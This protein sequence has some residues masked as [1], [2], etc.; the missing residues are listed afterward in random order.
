MVTRAPLL[1]PTPVHWA[2]VG[3]GPRQRLHSVRGDSKLLG[4]DLLGEGGGAAAGVEGRELHDDAAVLVD[5]GGGQCG[6]A[7]LAVVPDGN[8]PSDVGGLRLAPACGLCGLSE[9]FLGADGF[10]VVPASQLLA[11]VDDVLKPELQRVHAN[12]ACGD[13]HVGFPCED[14]LM[15]AGGLGKAAGDGV[16]VELAN[17]HLDVGDAIGAGNV[18]DAAETLGSVCGVGARGEEYFRLPGGDGA[19]LLDAGLDP[20]DGR[21]TGIHCGEFL[22]VLHDELDRPSCCLGQQVA[23]VGPGDVHLSAER[24]SEVGEVG[25][26]LLLGQL[27]DAGELIAPNGTHLRRHPELDLAVGVD[28]DQGGVGLYV[29]LVAVRRLIGALDDHVGLGKTLLDVALGS[30][31]AVNE[32]GRCFLRLD[33]Y[34][35]VEVGVQQ[36]AVLLEGVL[37]CE[38]GGEF[39]V[40]DMDEA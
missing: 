17:V 24:P 3:V 4:D 25:G 16:G 19:V 11:V 23:D 35:A 13:V 21:V 20:H 33:P 7:G 1:P 26:D 28:P 39:F 31:D 15:V 10:V 18:D 2:A 37:G 5:G 32:I 34:V 22:G 27:V 36:G 29:R 6:A 38:D 8:S 9:G 12:G 30:G 40:F 14:S